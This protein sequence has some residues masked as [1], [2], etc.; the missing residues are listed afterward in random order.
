MPVGKVRA[1][2][3]QTTFIH[4]DSSKKQAPFPFEKIVNDGK[5][6][7][8]SSKGVIQ[9]KEWP[10]GAYTLEG[11]DRIASQLRASPTLSNAL[12]FRE[13]ISGF[14]R[15]FLADAITIE[16]H[17]SSKQMHK[18]KKFSLIVEIRQDTDLLVAEM[19]QNLRSEFSFLER[20]NK[21]KG[22]LVDLLR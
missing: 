15:N 3:S 5:L 21:I 13:A 16:H 14:L 22:M 7:S 4:K 9:E 19:E 11:I 8:I 10:E 12:S 6:N 18:R 2:S 17:L 1:K 20:L